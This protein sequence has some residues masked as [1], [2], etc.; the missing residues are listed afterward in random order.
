VKRGFRLYSTQDQRFYGGVFETEQ[1]VRDYA[2]YIGVADEFLEIRR[3][4]ATWFDLVPLTPKW[5]DH[6]LRVGARW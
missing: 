5:Y 6:V 3:G 2:V 1:E 4:T